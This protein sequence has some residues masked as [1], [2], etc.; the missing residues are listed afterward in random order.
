MEFS[1]KKA[2]KKQSKQYGKKDFLIPSVIAEIASIFMILMCVLLIKGNIN[3]INYD[4]VSS[5]CT[6]ILGADLWRIWL[7]LIYFGFPTLVMIISSI[8]AFMIYKK[9]P[10][11]EKETKSIIAHLVA[12]ILLISFLI[13]TIIFTIATVYFIFP[14]LHQ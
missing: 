8:I 6:G 14:S 2:N 3:L 1:A 10:K 12:Q 7:T 5:P 11:K 4:C 9:L 13:L